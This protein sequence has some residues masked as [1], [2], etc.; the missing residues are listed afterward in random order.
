METSLDNLVLLQ[1]T[2]MEDSQGEEIIEGDIVKCSDDGDPIVR[3]VKWHGADGY[4]A[5][6]LH[7]HI[8]MCSNN[9]SHFRATGSIE[10]IGNIY[11]HYELM[12]ES[13]VQI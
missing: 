2:G 9:L 5:F 4:P 6:D 7:P 1:H 3:Y 8:E 13:G 10:V 12:G 11:E